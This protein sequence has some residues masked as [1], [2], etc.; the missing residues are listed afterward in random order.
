MVGFGLY[1]YIRPDIFMSTSFYMGLLYTLLYTRVY[2]QNLFSVSSIKLKI[3]FYISIKITIEKYFTAVKLSACITKVTK[4]AIYAPVWFIRPV[5]WALEIEK[6]LGPVKWHRAVRRV[7]F[8]A[9]PPP[10]L[11]TS[12]D[13][14]IPQKELAKTRSQISFIY[15]RSHSWYSVRNYVIPKGIMKTRFEPRLPRML[16]WKSNKNQ[17]SQ[18][19]FELRPSPSQASI[20]PLDHQSWYIISPQSWPCQD[21]SWGIKSARPVKVTGKNDSPL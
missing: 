10:T 16:S 9:Q 8:G 2:R 19:G 18:P 5:R 20:L 1:S 3:G 13:I 12:L 6:F 7:P 4:I 17:T 14:C 11:Q 15:F 21:L